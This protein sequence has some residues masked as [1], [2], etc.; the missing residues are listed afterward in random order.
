MAKQEENFEA[1]N[2][3][4]WT[5]LTLA[6]WLG[7]KEATETL[8]DHGANVNATVESEG[9]TALMLAARGGNADI[10]KLLLDNGASIK[11]RDKRG[12]TLLS[13]TITGYSDHGQI[14]IIKL[15]LDRGA[16]VNASRGSAL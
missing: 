4:G 1:E 5:A 16:Q 10:M 15:L 11:G 2:R 14:D 3:N 12:R 7:N 8:L 6:A 9:R 13:L